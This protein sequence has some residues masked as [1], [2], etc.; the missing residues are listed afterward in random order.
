MVILVKRPHSRSVLR[1]G[2]WRRYVVTLDSP[3][4]QNR[5]GRSVAEATPTRGPLATNEG[6]VGVDGGVSRTGPDPSTTEVPSAELSTPSAMTSLAGPRA[7]S[8]SGEAP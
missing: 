3:C 2:V 7:R 5:H 8:R 6:S 1:R 4:N